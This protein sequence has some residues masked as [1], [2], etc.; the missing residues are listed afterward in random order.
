[1]ESTMSDQ[2]FSMERNTD[3]E[4]MAVSRGMEKKLVRISGS[5]KKFTARKDAMGK[6]PTTNP[7]MS[8][9]DL[10]VV[11]LFFRHR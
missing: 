8:D 5:F 6:L 2:P 4:R 1:M 11:R 7:A 3:A 9:N 10:V